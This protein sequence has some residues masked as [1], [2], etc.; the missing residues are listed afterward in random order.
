MTWRP[1]HKFGAIKSEADGYKF[2]SRLEKDSYLQIKRL[3][4]SG[5]VRTFLMQTP[6]EIGGGKRH[7]IDFVVFTESNVLFL[8]SKGRDLEAGKL[9]RIL[10]SKY[11]GI[12]IHVVKKASEIPS[13]IEKFDI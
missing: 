7:R 9:R 4:E 6:L 5:K 1:R 12:D 8:E 13:L 3:Q 11:H 10:A 2:P